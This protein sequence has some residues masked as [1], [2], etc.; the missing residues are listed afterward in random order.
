MTSSTNTLSPANFAT[1]SGSPTLSY[2]STTTPSTY[3]LPLPSPPITRMYPVLSLADLEASQKAYSDLLHAAKSYRHSLASMSVSASNFGGA[4]EACA[5]LKEARNETLEN[6]QTGKMGN[7]WPSEAAI[8]GRWRNCTAD[9]LMAASGV[10]QLI[11][12]HHQIIS[13]TIYRNFEVPLMH[14]IDQ[15]RRKIEEEDAS[16]QREVKT[17]TKEIR[18]MEKYGLKLQKSRKRELGKFREHLVQ[19]TRKIDALTGLG[20]SYGGAVAKDCQDMSRAILDCSASVVRAEVE[21]YEALARKG[22]NGGG[23]DEL[24]EKGRDLFACEDITEGSNRISSILPQHISILAHEEPLAVNSG[25]RRLSKD[26]LLLDAAGYH[27][28]NEIIHDSEANSIFSAHEINTNTSSRSRNLR[29]RS[30]ILGNRIQVKD[31]LEDWEQ[32]NFTSKSTAKE[33]GSKDLNIHKKKS[34]ENSSSSISKRDEII[35]EEDEDS[36][37]AVWRRMSGSSGTITQK[38]EGIYE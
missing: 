15:W 24:L 9:S 20:D 25:H 6:N 12:N 34:E 26:S 5:R 33:I 31:P 37:T 38:D 17:M 22:W 19:L 7:I 11:A 28:L 35:A 1:I 14:E 18:S 3:N 4:L 2:V 32:E 8:M 27:S 23:L 30:P 10:H 16:Y 13:E 36:T 29:Q 21:I